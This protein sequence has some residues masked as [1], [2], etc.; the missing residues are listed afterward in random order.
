MRINPRDKEAASL[1]IGT[2]ALVYMEGIFSQDF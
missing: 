1:L 2:S